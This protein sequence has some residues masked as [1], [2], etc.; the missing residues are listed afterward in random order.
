M[1]RG[2]IDW[3]EGLI[4]RC[5]QELDAGSVETWTEILRAPDAIRG[6]GP[7][8]AA[9]VERARARVDALCATL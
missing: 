2:L 1:E 9:N 6:F 5:V 4:D 3:Y 7:V 8:K